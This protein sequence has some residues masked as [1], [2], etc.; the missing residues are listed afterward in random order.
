MRRPLRVGEPDPERA[1]HDLEEREQ[2]DLGRREQA[3]PDGQ[4]R[5]AERPSGRRRARRRS[6]SR[7][8]VADPNDANGATTTTT[9][10]CEA[11]VAG[12]IETSRRYRVITITIANEN[13]ITIGSADG[14]RAGVE[15]A[16]DHRPDADRGHA[17]IAIQVR[18]EIRSDRIAQPSSA[19]IIGA[20]AC[21]KRTFATDV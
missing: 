13:V 21:R 6:P 8:C 17:A 2:R 10:A 1:E 4:Q 16:D 15:R 19:A 7:S 14:Q 9:S 11:Q 18:R 5:E 3:R 20:D 12:I